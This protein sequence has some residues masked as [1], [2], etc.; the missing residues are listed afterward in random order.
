MAMIG[1][2]FVQ[3]AIG[4]T[5]FAQAIDVNTLQRIQGIALDFLIVSA[6]ASI[7]IPVIIN[8]A[9]PF[10]IL[11]LVAG[12][13][14]VA[15]FFWAGP[16]LFK[17]NW[18]ENSIIN[19]GFLS[20]VAAVGLMLL[21]TVDPDM[22]TDVGQAFALRTPIFEP[23]LGGGLITS[24]LPILAVKYGSLKTGLAFLV[25][26]LVLIVLAKFTGYWCVSEKDVTSHSYSMK[27]MAHS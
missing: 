23:F 13:S 21:R 15:F 2:F 4:K 16:K 26:A 19:F 18:F 5:K 10:L 6:I 14:L 25:I 9:L 7:K 11:M 1:G 22:E 27:T 17:E 12:T 20:G 8:Y 24:I 3:L